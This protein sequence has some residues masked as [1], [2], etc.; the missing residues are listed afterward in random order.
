MGNISGG[1]GGGGMGGYLLLLSAGLGI[2]QTGYFCCKIIINCNKKMREFPFLTLLSPPPAGIAIPPCSLGS[3]GG[4]QAFV[5][6]LGVSQM[7][8]GDEIPL[9][10]PPFIDDHHIIP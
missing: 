9:S 7:A 3:R 10:M 8:G 1:G 6:I 2:E 5:C 4:F